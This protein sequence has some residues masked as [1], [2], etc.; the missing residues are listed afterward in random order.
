MSETYKGDYAPDLFNEQ[1]HYYLLQAQEKANLTDAE[2]RDLNLLSNTFTRRFIQ[3][4][5][6]NAASVGLGFKILQSPNTSDQTNDFLI[7]S[8]VSYLQGYRLFLNNSI[9]YSDQTK[10]VD[11]TSEMAITQDGYTE[12]ILPSLNTPTG[13]NSNLYGMS[14]SG[15]SIFSCGDNVIVKTSDFGRNWDIK[16]T[17]SN[18]K[19]VSFCNSTTGVAVGDSGKIRITTNGGNLWVTQTVTPS[20]TADFKSV[21]LVNPLFAWAVGSDATIINTANLS[22]WSVQ[23]PLVTNAHL[24]GI[25]AVDTV[26]AWAVGANGTLIYTSTSGAVWNIQSLTGVSEDLYAVQAVDTTSVFIVGADGTFV[27]TLNGT[28]WQVLNIGTHENLRALYFKDKYTGWTVGDNGV[29]AQ[30]TNSGI[31]WSIK[32]IAPGIDFKSIVFSDTTGFINGTNGKIYRTLDGTN[33]EPYRTDYVYI[34][35]HLAEVSG[36][37][38]SGSEYIDPGLIDSTI[39][40][41]SANRLRLISDVKVSEGWPIPSDYSLDGTVMHYTSTLASIFRVA[42]RESILQSDITDHRNVVSTLSELQQDLTEGKIDTSSLAD[43]AVT[44][45]KIS[46]T[47]DYIVNSISTTDYATINGHLLVVDGIS[48]LGD[49]FTSNAEVYGNLRVGDTSHDNHE[50]LGS[51]SQ[52][53]DGTD[54]S[55]YK[56]DVI[57]SSN[58]MP[59]FNI[60]SLATGEIFNIVRDN[61]VTTENLFNISSNSSGYDFNIIH[62]IGGGLLKAQDDGTGTSIDILKDSSNGTAINIISTSNDPTVVINNSSNSIFSNSISVIQNKGTAVYLESSDA[63][64]LDIYTINKGDSI[65]INHVGTS[66]SSLDV[67][68]SSNSGAVHII[69]NE[70][71]AIYIKQTSNETLMALDKTGTGLGLVVEINNRGSDVGLG[72]Y[73]TGTGIAQLIS[74]V[75]DSTNPALDIYSDGNESGPVLRINKSNDTTG[76]AVKIWNQGYSETINITHDRTDSSA[77]AISINNQS[78]GKDISSNNWYVDNNGNFYTNGTVTT[79]VS[80]A[81]TIYDTTSTVLGFSSILAKIIHYKK[82]GKTVAV[83]FYIE[84]ISDS[85]VFS[86]TLPYYPSNSTKSLGVGV[87]YDGTNNFFVNINYPD[88]SNIGVQRLPNNNNGWPAYGSKWA[89]GTFVFEQT[90]NS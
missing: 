3:D 36:D 21:I 23:P 87:G 11:H 26:K 29:L 68:S 52:Y 73:N 4:Q 51:I 16:D 53:Y 39:G 69:N 89:S 24:Y 79:S 40:L 42:N 8:G 35:F 28:N 57:D 83:N 64:A 45:S 67:T 6:G 75:G 77:S 31:T 34:D 80:G 30:T 22:L 32:T 66:G 61:T 37:S 72:V 90:D 50:I 70:G 85:S 86:F 78:T 13:T 9:L 7:N 88:N 76:E 47:G 56:I 18:F 33:W 12:T 43:G 82:D 60:N 1:K 27:R 62:S 55:V 46:S 2:L 14:V 25:S 38:T 63:V 5:V 58:N 49:I 19:S 20:S 17:G 10:F 59:V 84:G 74:H 65:H 81:W 54:N 71:Q 44:P 15:T 48:Y 41:P